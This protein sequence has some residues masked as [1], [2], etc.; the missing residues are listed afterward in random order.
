MPAIAYLLLQLVPLDRPYANGLLLLALAPCAPFAPAMV[1][2]AR[3]DPAY[4]AA[5][6]MLS[7]GATVVLMPVM[8]PL[9]IRGFAADPVAIARPLLLFVLLP[10]ALGMTIN[11]AS[12]RVA[13]RARGSVA[14]ITH[15]TGVLLLVVIAVIHGGG[16]IDAVGSFAIATQ[17]VF[18]GAVSV[19]AHLFGTGLPPEQRSVLTLG[20][21]SRNLGAALVP[22]ATID[23]DPR[24]VVMIAIAAPVTLVLSAVTARWLARRN[25][26]LS[27]AFTAGSA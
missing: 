17:V 11:A 19:T 16:V 13:K 12:E 26:A 8:V 27:V 23:P 15:V 10:L 24:A 25:R 21:S 6:M 14:L 9:M 5:F 7:A 22:L 1:R 4:M 18:I 20:V 3:G 2:V